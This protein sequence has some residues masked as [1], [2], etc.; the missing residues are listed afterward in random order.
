MPNDLTFS[1]LIKACLRET[2]ACC[3]KQIH[4]HVV[5]SGFSCDCYVCSGLVGVYAKGV[6][7]LV[8]ARKVF[9]EMSD[10][11]MACCWTSLIVG[12]AEL[13]CSGE[14]LSLFLSMVKEKL[15]PEN[16]AVVNVLS[17]CSNLD[18]VSI[19]NWVQRLCE[20]IEN[21]RCYILDLDSIKTLLVY[22][23]GKLEKVDRS[24]EIYEKIS[25]GGKR[26][27]LP[28]NVMIN[29][30]VQNDSPLEALC[31][32]SL[33]T[34]NHSCKPNH[35]TMVSV[36][37]ACSRTGDLDRGIWV[38]DYLKSQG[39]KGILSLNRNLGT[40]LID[41]YCKCG[42]LAKAKEVFDQMA[43]KDIVSVNAMI[44]GLAIN[45]KGEEALRLFEKI[46]RF[47]VHPN[48][49]TV[50]AVLYAC[51]HS[52]LLENG[53]CIFLNMMHQF[54]ILPKLEHY[55]CY[56]D[57]LSRMGH[58]EE[59]LEVVNSMPFEPNNLV[60]GALLGGC[61]LHNRLDLAQNISK[62]F[63]ETDPQNSAGY[64]M[65]SNAFA[66]DSRWGDVSGLRWMMR[67]KGVRK[68]PGRS[69]IS[70]EGI[71]HEFVAGSLSHPRINCILSMLDGLLSEMKLS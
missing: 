7:D 42:C 28:W 29:A 23:Y 58:I 45:G 11:S 5:K 31:I 3:V 60:L 46:D 49:G 24:R 20:F 54:S 34:E 62:I 10:R 30:Y 1:F 71:V 55:S 36:L 16:D 18:I 39:R 17:V 2:N 13:G 63:V 37:S 51:S 52:G 8:S 21:E 69:W 19:Q 15:T 59:A 44:M 43:H 66:G 41:M 68:Q 70:I 38:H 47:G 64:V 14:V 40:S 6:R 50:L 26:S 33:M 4:T 48:D 22:L 53:C 9:D 35:V 65:L 32:F 67:E 12:F 57:L 61:L 56:I 27:G 25:D